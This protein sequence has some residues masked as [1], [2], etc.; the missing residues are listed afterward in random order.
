MNKTIAIHSY[1]GGTGKTTVSANLAYAL[2]KEGKNVCVLD[3]DFK[4]PSLHTIFQIPVN[5]KDTKCINDVLNKD[6]EIENVIKDIS[7][8]FNTE[9]KLYVGLS[10]PQ[11]NA[12]VHM[13]A[14]GKKWQ[15]S[16]LKQLIDCKK[17][18]YEI[19]IDIIILDTTPGVE[20]SSINAIATADYT[21]IVL[22]PDRTG[23]EGSTELIRNIYEELKMDGG[24]II[25]QCVDDDDDEVDFSEIGLPVLEHIKCNCDISCKNELASYTKPDHDFSTAI[26]RIATMIIDQ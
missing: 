20:Y 6:C 7:H 24:L 17:H 8:Q 19:G 3:L 23:V 16:A 25:N 4:A 22:K 15:A 26:E 18:L 11:S 10:N 2:A 1:K 5:K 9:G 21:M 14:K 13:S 12:L